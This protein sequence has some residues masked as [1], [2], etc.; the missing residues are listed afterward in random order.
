MGNNLAKQTMKN[1][2]YKNHTR[3]LLV[4]FVA[5]VTVTFSS[6]SIAKCNTTSQTPSICELIDIKV[7]Q[8]IKING[9]Y[10]KN[11]FN[12]KYN[13]CTNLIYIGAL[14]SSIKE[15]PH[16]RD[17]KHYSKNYKYVSRG[18]YFNLFK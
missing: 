9:L 15:N 11:S 10:L 18:Y 12:A 4:F 1:R 2:E 3:L 14:T 16:Y 17:S 7:Y 8:F 5:L 13:P 6:R